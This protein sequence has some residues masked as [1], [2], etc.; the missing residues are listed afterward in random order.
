M[1]IFSLTQIVHTLREGNQCADFL[2]KLRASSNDTLLLHQQ[3]PDDLRPMIRTRHYFLKTLV[4]PFV[5]GSFSF[6]SVFPF[7]QCNQKKKKSSSTV[8]KICLKC[9][10]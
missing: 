3:P 1:V 7:Q 4:F 9:G 8:K 6:F 2:A 10:K 5:W